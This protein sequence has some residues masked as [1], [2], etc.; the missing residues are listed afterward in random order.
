M[1]KKHE[2]NVT[3]DAADFQIVNYVPNS[4]V[5]TSGQDG[6]QPA[7][8]THKAPKWLLSINCGR[9]SSSQVA[10]QWVKDTGGA[11][12]SYAPDG[13]GSP[14]PSELNFFYAVDV[15]T[16]SGAKTRLYLGQGNHG[17]TNNW[18]V[19][20]QD[21]VAIDNKAVLA[22]GSGDSREDFSLS[23]NHETIVFKKS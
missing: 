19:G 13:G 23:G 7:S 5:I 9:K 8:I 6:D 15:T 18:W 2:N 11:K 14:P 21:V 17:L 16:Y 12:N 22:V 1:S 20:G 4:L 10:S 3:L